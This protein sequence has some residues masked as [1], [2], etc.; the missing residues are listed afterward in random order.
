MKGILTNFRGSRR[1][2]RGDYMLISIPDV[3]SREKA[4]ALIGKKV[5]WVA[6]GKNNTTIT[7]TVTSA[8]G[9]SGIVRAQF[10]RGLPGQSLGKEVTL[11]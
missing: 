4:Q 6:E 2:K 8:H 3:T 1:V 9:N 10:E 7:G 5:K 11:E